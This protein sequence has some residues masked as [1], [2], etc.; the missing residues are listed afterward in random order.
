MTRVIGATLSGTIVVLALASVGGRQTTPSA[1]R[2]N[3]VVFLTD[4]MGYGDLQSYGNP[5]IRTPNLDQMARD[6]I[7]LTSFYASAPICTPSRAGFLTGRYA[8]RSGLTAALGPGAP[9]GIADSETTLAEVLKTRGYRTAMIGKWHLGDRPE[10]NPTRHGFDVFYGLPYSNDYRPP[11]VPNT[12]QVPLLKDL[13]VI[14]RP[15][16]QDTLTARYTDE[17]IRFIGEAK[18]QPFF[19]YLA[20][21]MPHLPISTPER[22]RGRSRGGP[23]GDVIEELDWSVGEV[24]NALK[25]A[26]V[27]RDTVA[28]F[29]S[30]NGPW[31]NAGDRMWQEGMTLQH[32]G[33]AGPLRDAKGTTYEG[34]V[35]V[36]GIVRWPA[37]IRAGQVSSEMATNMDFLPTFAHLAGTPLPPNRPL[38]GHDITS[39]LTG[40]GP[41]ATNEF[42]YFAARNLQ[43]VRSGPWK[44][45]AVAAAVELYDLD[46][47]P[48]ERFN[49]ASRHPDVVERLRARLEAFRAETQAAGGR[50]GGAAPSQ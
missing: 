10:F 43:A 17:A 28:V 27:D 31:T 12:P 13:D 40:T 33:S 45:R 39:L 14:E 44:L 23:Y 37:R 24:L 11:F 7:R 22:F 2:P 6:G 20:Y 8:I 5:V 16:N 36:P 15:V 3:F 42:F 46:V 47:D 26:G 21:N 50:Q 30:D 4:D 32:V 25:T 35:R 19:L 1:P 9:V 29:M 38:D 41:S 18:G 48:Y 49:V 34:G